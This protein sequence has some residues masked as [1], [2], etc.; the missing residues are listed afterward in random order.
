[1]ADEI[2]EQATYQKVSTF[3]SFIYT[4]DVVNR[5]V[6][7]ELAKQGTTSRTG[8][9]VLHNLILHGGSMTPTRISERIFRSKHTVTKII[10]TL[11]KQGL[12]RREPIG[13]DR[14]T[15]MVSITRKGLDLI[16]RSSAEGRERVSRE[17]FQP[18]NDNQI[19]ELGTVLKQIRKYL[20]NV[21]SNY[22]T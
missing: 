15:R 14:R 7:I 12:V 20:L 16:K 6:D 11:E 21:I 22:K 1:M 5:Y 19:E 8:I 18:L 2:R 17:V 3:L 9:S 13:E 4:A 10:D